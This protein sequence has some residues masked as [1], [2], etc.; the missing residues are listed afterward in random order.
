MP[1]F[2]ITSNLGKFQEAKLILPELEQLDID[3]DEIQDASPQKVVEH[4]LQQAFQHHQGEFIVEDTSLT[5]EAMNGLPGPFIKWFLKALGTSGLSELASKLNNTKAAG[6]SIIGYAEN[7]QEIH[8]FE[9]IVEGKIVSP[10]GEGRMG[11]D[12]IFQ[13]D[14]ETKTFAEMSREEKGKYSMRGE[15]VRKLKEFLGQ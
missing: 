11:W 1:L 6:Q 15:A 2:F 8:F 9:G 13:P 14:G 7:P 3:L 10:R 12:P 5:F 4:K